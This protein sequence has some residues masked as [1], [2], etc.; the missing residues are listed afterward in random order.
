VNGIRAFL[1]KKDN[2]ESYV[3]T[4]DPDII[5]LNETKISEGD[6]D[7]LGDVFPGLPHVQWHFSTAKKGYSGTAIFSKQAPQHVLKGFHP[8]VKAPADNEGRVLTARFTHFTLIATYVPNSGLQLDRLSYRTEKWDSYLKK[9]LD[10][11]GREN[12]KLPLILCGDLNVAHRDMDV[13]DPKKKRNKVE[14]LC[15]LPLVLS[16]ILLSSLSHRSY[17]AFLI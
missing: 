4:E 8:S 11:I 10:A 13:T 7:A 5:C 2:W 17:A 15:F 16:V 3:Q 14:C 1:K 12:P 6:V 9:H